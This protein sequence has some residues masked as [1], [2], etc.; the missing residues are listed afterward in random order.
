M[1]KSAFTIK[2]F[3][4][5]LLGLGILLALVP[6]LLLSP[7]GIPPTNE[8]WIRVLGVVVINVGVH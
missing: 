3:G 1:S 2:V 7:F 4:V 5:Y 6:N 8:V